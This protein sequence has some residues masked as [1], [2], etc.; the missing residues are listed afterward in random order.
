[1]QFS[2]F[3]FFFGAECGFLERDL[4]VVTQIRAT[5]SIFATGGDSAKKRFKN[6]AANPSSAAKDFPENVERIVKAA[7]ETAT[8][9]KGSVTK[10]IVGGALVHIHQDVVG[11]AQ[12]FEF[13][14]GVRIVRIFVGMKFYRELAISALD[15]LFGRTTTDPE[16]FVARLVRD[17]FVQIRIEFLANRVDRLQSVFN[18]KILKLF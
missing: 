1:I 6:A 15:L 12:L 13:F 17:R 5:L 9:L 2:N 18:Q 4:H 8:L 16:D 3:D 14:L 7:A 10:A 11:L